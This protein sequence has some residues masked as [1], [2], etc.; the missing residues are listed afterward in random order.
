MKPRTIQTLRGEAR[1]FR[2]VYECP[3]CRGSYAP[4]DREMGVF[5][6]ERMTLRVIRKVAY[7]AAHAS[8]PASTLP[9]Y[10]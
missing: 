2:T 7:E 10:R 4:L 1:F 3:R 8:F 5:P 9:D 6:H